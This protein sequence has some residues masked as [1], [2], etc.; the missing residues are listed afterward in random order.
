MKKSRHTDRA[1]GSI[2]R[3]RNAYALEEKAGY[4]LDTDP[5]QSDECPAKRARGGREVEYQ[6]REELFAT[7]PQT[8]EGW[9]ALLRYVDI[10]AGDRPRKGIMTGAWKGSWRILETSHWAARRRGR[11][12][13]SVV[14]HNPVGS[15]PAGF[16]IRALR[17]SPTKCIYMSTGRRWFAR[18][19]L[20]IFSRT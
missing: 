1:F 16:L 2:K 12:H 9:M 11:R 13:I 18:A 17:E 15:S 7:V 14:L 4:E 8:S 20:R 19:V 6:A 5:D 3:H 10:L